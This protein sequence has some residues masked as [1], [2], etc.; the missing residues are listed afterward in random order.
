MPAPA[1]RGSVDLL[2]KISLRDVVFYLLI[3]LVLISLVTAMRNMDG[4]ES[5]I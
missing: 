1:A 4:S 5:A 3:F 2:K